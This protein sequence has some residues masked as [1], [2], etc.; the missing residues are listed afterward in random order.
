MITSPSLP[1]RLSSMLS[2]LRRAT[3]VD[4]TFGGFPATQRDHAV[5]IDAMIGSET[6]ALRG[7]LIGQGRGLGGKALALRQPAYVAEYQD[8]QGITHDYDNAV[9]SERL[10]AV[11]AVPFLISPDKIGLVYGALRSATPI[12]DRLIGQACTI[13]RRF[14]ARYRS[15]PG[16]HDG[17]RHPSRRHDCEGD[18]AR[19]RQQ[20]RDTHA[21][22]T[23]IL[24]S[25]SQPDARTRIKGLLAKLGDQA[26]GAQSMAGSDSRATLAP[27]E[28]DVLSLVA[29]GLPNSEIA[30]DLDLGLPTVKA[31]LRSA[32]RKLEARNRVEAVVIASRRGIIP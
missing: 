13:V 10:R 21:E 27:R 4:V 19:M 24:N 6:D 29:T 3:G 14:E 7:L 5:V 1:E 18:V 17:V 25:V 2:Q 9:S 32:C 22:L 8:A 26:D 11:F 12:G 23:V 20:L 28:L 30:R 16:F 31:Y 15:G